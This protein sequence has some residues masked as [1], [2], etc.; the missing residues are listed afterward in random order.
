M[1]AV[2]E[3]SDSL[4]RD[5]SA[6]ESYEEPIMKSNFLKPQ[7]PAKTDNNRDVFAK[8]NKPAPVLS[9]RE[10]LKASMA[11]ITKPKI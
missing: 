10:K 4:D 2:D 8:P 7:M 9:E 3:A 5:G 6:S 11:N 1:N